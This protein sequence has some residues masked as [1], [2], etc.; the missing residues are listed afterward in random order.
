MPRRLNGG[1]P[2]RMRFRSFRPILLDEAAPGG[3]RVLGSVEQVLAFL[4]TD[5]DD[6]RRSDWQIIIAELKNAKL[7]ASFERGHKRLKLALYKAG[8]LFEDLET[9]K[10]KLAK[11]RRVV[12]KAYPQKNKLLQQIIDELEQMLLAL[13]Q[14]ADGG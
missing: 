7:G 11:T 9:L 5:L 14:G 4:E 13:K 3:K 1:E 6:Q 10:S 12:A 8:W 2:V